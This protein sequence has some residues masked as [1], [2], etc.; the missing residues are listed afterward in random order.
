M[1]Q[2]IAARHDAKVIKRSFDVGSLVLRRN[3]KDSYE[4]KLAANWEG[5]YRVRGKTDNGAS[6]LRQGSPI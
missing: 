1:K 6:T 5:L 2:K 4:G 3:A